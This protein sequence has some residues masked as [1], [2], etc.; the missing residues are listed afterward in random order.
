MEEIAA[1]G[2]GSPRWIAVYHSSSCCLRDFWNREASSAT[3]L[4]TR[5]GACRGLRPSTVGGF[6]PA[7][8][9]LVG[10]VVCPVGAGRFPEAEK[11]ACLLVDPPLAVQVVSGVLH[12]LL[13][14]TTCEKSG[15]CSL[16]SPENPDPSVARVA[17]SNSRVVSVVG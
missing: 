8:P 10:R 12:I 5:A 6:H 13:D 11:S 1:G 14:D 15:R 4:L 16:Y 3:S 17:I 7:L 2:K 9:S